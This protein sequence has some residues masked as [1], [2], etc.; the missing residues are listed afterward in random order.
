[1]AQERTTNTHLSQSKTDTRQAR[2]IAALKAIGYPV[3]RDLVN[4]VSCPLVIVC[5]QQSSRE[6]A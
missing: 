2:L 5:P 6:A 3:Q 4:G 1:M